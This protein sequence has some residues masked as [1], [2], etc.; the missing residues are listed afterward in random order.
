MRFFRKNDEEAQARL[1]ALQQALASAQDELTKAWKLAA[2]LPTDRVVC[3]LADAA[4]VD[5]V[6]RYVREAGDVVE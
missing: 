4:R 1:Q 6:E 2:L 3:L 5:E